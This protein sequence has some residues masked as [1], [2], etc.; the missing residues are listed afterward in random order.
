MDQ[1][2]TCRL[3]VKIRRHCFS[4]TENTKT[5]K[6]VFDS[7]SSVKVTALGHITQ[8][9]SAKNFLSITPKLMDK[10]CKNDDLVGPLL[11]RKLT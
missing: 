9:T 5:L 4:R 1:K 11:N 8:N 10:A 7:F 3:I 2:L 6:S